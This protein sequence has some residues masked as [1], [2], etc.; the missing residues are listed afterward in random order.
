M[1]V[2]P[3]GIDQRDDFKVTISFLLNSLSRMTIFLFRLYLHLKCLHS[4][5]IFFG[6]HLTMSMFSNEVDAWQ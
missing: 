5:N 2:R 1:Y 4:S 6:L 3:I